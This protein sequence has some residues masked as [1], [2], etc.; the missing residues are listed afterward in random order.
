LRKKGV[1]GLSQEPLAVAGDEQEAA[2][3]GVAL[4]VRAAV[5]QTTAMTHVRAEG[6]RCV[7]DGIREE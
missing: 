2:R 1:K 7:R 3:P 5:R 6:E 4:P